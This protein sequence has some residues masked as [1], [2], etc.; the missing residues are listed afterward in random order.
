MTGFRPFVMIS[1]AVC[2]VAWLLALLLFGFSVTDRDGKAAVAF[3]LVVLSVSGSLF[4]LSA[5]FEHY[6]YALL[7]LS[8]NLVLAGLSVLSAVAVLT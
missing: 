4:G 8:V 2:A 3:V 6:R 1:S 7:A 5:W